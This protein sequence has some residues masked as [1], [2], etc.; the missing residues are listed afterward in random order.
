[1]TGA[2]HTDFKHQKDT[3]TR[4]WRYLLSQAA[5]EILDRTNLRGLRTFLAVGGDVFDALTFLEGLEAIALDLGEM[6]E[7]IFAAALRRD[8]TEA[9]GFIE[10]LDG[11]LCHEKLPCKE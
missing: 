9:F 4:G 3:A 5:S 6:R 2:Q 7:E 11:T 1:M 10:P 8:E